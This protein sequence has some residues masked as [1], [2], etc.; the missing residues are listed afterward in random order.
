M[1]KSQHVENAFLVVVCVTAMVSGEVAAMHMAAKTGRPIS[2]L[3]GPRSHAL[4]LPKGS[5]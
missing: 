3:P 5:E 1:K 2:Y 4:F